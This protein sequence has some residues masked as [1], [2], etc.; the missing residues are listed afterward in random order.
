[1][2]HCEYSKH[3]AAFKKNLE[4]LLKHFPAFRGKVMKM[5]FSH[6]P[7][8][9]IEALNSLTFKKDFKN[10]CVVG[11]GGSS[12]GAKALLSALGSTNVEFLD[13][14]DPD[15]VELKLNGLDPKQTLFV[16]ISKSGETVEVL[17]LASVLLTKFHSSK[18]FLIITDNKE[19]SLGKLGKKHSIHI[20]QSQKELPGRFSVLSLVGLLPA[21]LAGVPIQ[22]VLNGAR[23]ASWPQAYMFACYQYLHYKNKK[24]ISVIF[25]YSERLADFADWYI[26]LLSESIGKSKKVGITP[27]KALGVKDQHSQLQLFLDGPD[28]KF[29][30]FLKPRKT[31]SNQKIPGEKYNLAELFDA[32]Y[33]GVKGAFIKKQKPFLELDFDS[34]SP[35]VLGELFLF[36]ELQIAFLGCLFKINCENQPAVE[37][38]KRATQ[39]LL[40]K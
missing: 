35:E 29:C 25:P 12:L 22:R 21:V 28:D 30:I 26:Q 14:I 32:E 5:T 11:I 18:N 20:F 33:N 6:L 24:N 1:M 39:T 10:I 4:K 15:Y 37:L 34:I 16:L 23:S 19:S 17:S 36:F 40:K 2:L 8:K 31:E 3:S 27:L 38:S 9:D 13:N 7:W